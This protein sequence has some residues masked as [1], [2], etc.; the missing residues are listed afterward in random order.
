MAEI[1]IKPVQSKDEWEEFLKI[2]PES[3]FLQ[4]WYWGEFHIRLA[5]EI[6]RLG[7]YREQKLI[8]VCLSIVEPARRGRYLTVP[9]G[10][11]IDWTD[12]FLVTAFFDEIRRI[13]KDEHCVFI[14]IRPQLTEDDHSQSLFKT[15]GAKLAPMHLHAELTNQLDIT[16]SEDELLVNMR[17]ATRYEIKKGIKE[18]VV[19]HTTTHDS[20]MK[21]FY[22]L[23]IQTAKRQKFVPF[24]FRFLDEQFRVF[25][26]SGNA[27]LVTE[28]KTVVKLLVFL[29]KK[30]R[31]LQELS[32]LKQAII[33]T[34]REL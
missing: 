13:A 8:G 33:V 27:L 20:D 2:H 32:L 22:D 25:S 26:E 34:W 24:S 28:Q 17:K 14:R 12:T 1:I 19:V 29:N 15:Y 11:I 30:C 5:H 23:Q 16:K 10:P 4:S 18:G 9:G 6:Q 21:R 31:S 3:D 7:F